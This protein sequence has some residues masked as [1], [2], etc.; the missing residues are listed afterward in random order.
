MTALLSPELPSGGHSDIALFESIAVSIREQGY[1]INVF[2]L[3]DDLAVDLHQLA[4]TAPN[5]SYEPAG[6][7]RENTHTLNARVRSD[8]IRWINSGSPVADRWLAWSDALRT[9]LNRRLL[10]GLFSFESHFAHYGRGDFYKRHYDAFKGSRNRVLSLVVYLN[11]E[12]SLVDGGQLVIYGGDEDK[13]GIQVLPTFGTIV[14]FLSEEFPHEVLPANRDRFSIAGW[15]RVNDS[16]ADK[17][18]PPE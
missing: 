16:N 2:A 9:H 13:E 10:L 12:W 17:V 5:H 14:T 11:P 8:Q 7:G 18:N 4:F 1:S 6:I 15:F 3:P